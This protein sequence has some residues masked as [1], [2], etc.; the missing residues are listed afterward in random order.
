MPKDWQFDP[1]LEATEQ[2][3]LGVGTFREVSPESWVWVLS[4]LADYIQVLSNFTLVV[5]V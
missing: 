5:N 3:I 4:V 2:V 1:L